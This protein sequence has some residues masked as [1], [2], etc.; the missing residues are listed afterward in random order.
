MYYEDVNELKELVNYQGFWDEVVLVPKETKTR[1]LNRIMSV[2]GLKE[3][4][5][6]GYYHTRTREFDV[7]DTHNFFGDSSYLPSDPI[8][9]DVDSFLS[10]V[11][12]AVKT[13][14]IIE[15]MFSYGY[16]WKW[17]VFETAE[18]NYSRQ[19][20]ANVFVGNIIKYTFEEVERKGTLIELPEPIIEKNLVALEESS[21]W[22]C[23][24]RYE[25]GEINQEV[26]GYVPTVDY[27]VQ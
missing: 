23:L 27:L 26:S 16:D 1:S 22:L 15:L 13:R 11:D 21:S 7:N 20:I 14:K 3:I 12:N 2:S 24:V 6:N 18:V 8:T 5:E 25:P 10:Q 4:V 9:Y 17:Y 19:A